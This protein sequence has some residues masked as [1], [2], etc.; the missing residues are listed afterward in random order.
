MSK[1][2]LVT[3]GGSPEPVLH[4]VRNHNPDEVIFIPSVKPT[5]RPSLDQVVGE[6]TPCRHELP[7]GVV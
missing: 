1:V 3:V 4:T 5:L 6:G 7:N 2:L